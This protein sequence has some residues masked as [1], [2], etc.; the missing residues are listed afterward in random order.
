MRATAP[1]AAS[2]YHGPVSPTITP[3]RGGSA[4]VGGGGK[5][6]GFALHQPPATGM[7]TRLTALHQHTQQVIDPRRRHAGARSRPAEDQGH[8]AGRRP[9]QHSAAIWTGAW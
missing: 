5:E 6:P 8:L 7:P 9:G 3:E 2:T 4:T 1:V